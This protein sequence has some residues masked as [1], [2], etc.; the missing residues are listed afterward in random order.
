MKTRTLS[1]GRTVAVHDNGGLRKR[2]RCARRKWS[3]C[4]HSWTFNFT[5]R[6]TSYR[7]PL[8]RY[9]DHRLVSRDEAKHEADRLRMLI[10]GGTFPPVSEA[11]SSPTALTFD[12]FGD[13]WNERAR[14][15]TTEVQQRNDRILL[16]RLGNLHIGD[17][18]LGDRTI[19]RITEDD[20]ETAFRGLATLAAS[21]FNK[22]RQTILHLQRWGVKKG[23][24]THSWLSAESDIKRKKGAKRERRLVPDEID[25]GRVTV[26]GEERRLLD[27]ATPWLRTL[28]IAAL[29]TCCRRGELLSLRWR[30]VSLGRLEITLR[31]ENTKDDELRRLPLS[32]RLAG[33]IGMLR[34][35]PTG[36]PHPPD[37]HVFGNRIGQPI[38]D[39]KKAWMKTCREA[40]IT[41][42]KFHDLRH[43]AASRLLEAGWPL[44]AVQAML[45]HADAKT[46]SIYINT[47]LGQLHDSMRRFGTQSLHTLAHGPDLEPR[48]LGNDVAASDDNALVN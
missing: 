8:D 34:L 44:Q 25:H 33:V 29:E 40:G 21:T 45:G 37:A 7:F 31:A 14:L 27:H 18:R 19:G 4:P 20:L 5:W 9:S 3:T 12:A 47:T 28:I 16:R 2:C 26:P 38:K 15:A 39:P 11:E 6:E 10:R 35:D 1:T 36:Q 43:E 48:P 22:H 23:Y 24:L 46:A 17:D 30:D 32:P 42:L 41:D 13:L